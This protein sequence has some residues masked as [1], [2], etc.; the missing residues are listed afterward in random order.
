VES[1]AAEATQVEEA[2]PE[3]KDDPPPEQTV[4]KDDGTTDGGGET[5]GET[6]EDERPIT[7]TLRKTSGS[8]QKK[9][10]IKLSKVF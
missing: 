9:D 2:N 3:V 10:Q 8:C 4:A 5:A 7:A 1:T 6:S